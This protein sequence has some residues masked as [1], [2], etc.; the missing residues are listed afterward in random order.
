ML[1]LKNDS[2]DSILVGRGELVDI[3]IDPGHSVRIYE[4]DEKEIVLTF[5]GKVFKVSSPANKFEFS[6]EY[7]GYLDWHI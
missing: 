2:K 5:N 3:R 7:S 1:V 6:D 4:C